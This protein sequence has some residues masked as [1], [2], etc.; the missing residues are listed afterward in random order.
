MNKIVILAV[1]LGVVLIGWYVLGGTDVTTQVDTT[2]TDTEEQVMDTSPDM[3]TIVLAE[4]NESG[5]SGTAT[6]TDTDGGLNVEL[7]LVGASE[8]VEQ[9]AHIHLNNCADIGGVKYPLTFPVNG[10]STTVLQGV[11]LEMILADMPLSIN[12]HKSV[13]EASVY[14]ACGDIAPA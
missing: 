11:T 1:V 8:N 2:E 13:E 6:L 5:T 14:V 9:P 3:L 7:S 12:V 4:Q 10:E